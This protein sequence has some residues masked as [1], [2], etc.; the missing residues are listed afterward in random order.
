MEETWR[1]LS[2]HRVVNGVTIIGPDLFATDQD[3]KPL[4]PIASVFPDHQVI[5]A[6]RGIHALQVETML[7]F[8]RAKTFQQARRDLS[9]EEEQAVYMN[10]VSLLIRKSLVLIRSDPSAMDKVFAADE[11]LQRFLAKD[12]IQF[13]GIQLAEV[14][15]RLRHRGESW[16]IS[17]PPHSMQDIEQFIE[18][19]RVQVDTGAAYY[20]N[21]PTGGRYITY[22]EFMRIRPLL[23]SDMEE[24]LN[25]LTEISDLT[26]RANNMGSPELSFFLPSGRTLKNADLKNLTDVLKAASSE[27]ELNTAECLFDR[28][29][30]DFAMT[31][32]SDLLIDNPAEAAWRTTMFC[33]LYDINENEVEEWALGLSPEFRLN[34]RWL[35]GARLSTE[36]I[37]ES[38]SQSRI[39]DLI[40]HFWKTRPAL[41]S[42]NI[43]RVESPQTVRDRTGEQRDVYL[44]VLGLADG[45]ETIRLVRMIKWDVLHRVKRGVP[46]QQA[47]SETI[48]YRDYILDRLRAATELGIP[49]LPYTEIWLEEDVAQ[50]GRIPVFFFDRM[51]VPGVVTDKI[52]HGLYAKPGFTL[53]LSGLLGIAAA[54]SLILGR[55]CPRSGHVFFD[56]GDEVIQLNGDG[57]PER[58]VI[59]DTTGSFTDWS[60]PVSELLP[61]CL[62]HLAQHLDRAKQNGIG[63]AELKD[64]AGAFGESLRKEIARMQLLLNDPDSA[65]W[66]L[67][68]DRTNEPGGIRHRWEA[69]LCRLQAA[70][71]RLLFQ[72]IAASPHLEPFK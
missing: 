27:R 66:S 17:P 28:F 61:H 25:R 24:A 33:R 42:I 63:P 23:R 70:D 71:S 3:G 12:L 47:I 15:D 38:G 72:E 51:Y 49:K 68:A 53:K 48:Q 4:S 31:A 22:Q 16:R 37:F 6:G 13:T 67:F 39:Q 32:G 59:A 50:L 21:A 5:V 20:Y 1:V 41:A 2:N 11:L 7:D 52:P 35:P 44:A 46:L 29:A 19:S 8:L 30:A 14:R 18:S 55:A 62:W 40:R 9:K 58:L 10:S 43:G 57:L 69:I 34:V 26:Q 45:S 36:P 60:T 65:L 54:A 56:D 64:S